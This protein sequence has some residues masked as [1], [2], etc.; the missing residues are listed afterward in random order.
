MEDVGKS[1]VRPN[2]VDYDVGMSMT[3]LALEHG[4]DV[5]ETISFN[6]SF[7]NAL[8]H[9]NFSPWSQVHP[10]LPIEILEFLL[11]AGYDLEQQSRSGHTSLLFAAAQHAPHIVKCLRLFIER[12]ANKH[13]TDFEGQGVLHRALAA[14]D[15]YDDWSGTLKDLYGKDYNG[16]Y[17]ETLV[18]LYIFNTEDDRHE[19]DYDD[20][21]FDLGSDHGAVNE[22]SIDY[23]FCEGEDEDGIMKMIRNPIQVLKKRT[24]FKLL[25][26]LQLGCDPNVVDYEGLSPSDYAMEEGLW[27]QWRWALLNAGY[28]YDTQNGWVKSALF[29]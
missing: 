24:R 13:A 4:C 10:T 16:P 3:R 14:P 6:D 17:E 23:V 9:V 20:E 1:E 29:D 21:V 12:G 11:S 8:Y 5:Y 19:E 18:P 15:I 2:R 27:P 25:T 7:A 22:H 26:L 28:T